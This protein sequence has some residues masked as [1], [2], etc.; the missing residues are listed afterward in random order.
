MTSRKLFASV[1][2]SV[3]PE[4]ISDLVAKPLIPESTTTTA[5][6]RPVHTDY[7]HSTGSDDTDQTE[8]NVVAQA[9][10]IDKVKTITTTQVCTMMINRY[11]IPKPDKPAD[12]GV[13]D[14]NLSHEKLETN[15]SENPVPNEPLPKNE[16]KRDK[17]ISE[18]RLESVLE[19]AIEVD[20]G[21]RASLGL[22][23]DLFNVVPEQDVNVPVVSCEAVDQP[24]TIHLPENEFPLQDIPVSITQGLFTVEQDRI[25][26]TEDM[27]E[28]IAPDAPAQEP[29]IFNKSYTVPVANNVPVVTIKVT[30]DSEHLPLSVLS[31]QV[32]QNNDLVSCEDPI[33]QLAELQAPKAAILVG[34][35]TI[36][37]PAQDRSSE[38][39]FVL[40][41]DISF[42]NQKTPSKSTALPPSKLIFKYPTNTQLLPTQL[43]PHKKD[44]TQSLKTDDILSTQQI[45]A[46][47]F[48]VEDVLI[49]EAVEQ[50]MLL[51]G[52]SDCEWDD[53]GLDSPDT[54]RKNNVVQ[55]LKDEAGSS[56]KLEGLEYQAKV[57]D[58][59]NELSEFPAVLGLLKTGGG[60]AI[61]L[62]QPSKNV[63][64]GMDFLDLKGKGGQSA[65]PKIEKKAEEKSSKRD[66]FEKMFFSKDA[67]LSKLEID[68]AEMLPSASVLNKDPS[69][70]IKGFETASGKYIK[71]ISKSIFTEDFSDLKALNGFPNRGC[72][73]KLVD[74][75]ASTEGVQPFIG[76]KTAA[77]SKISVKAKS[78]FTEDFSDL[79]DMPSFSGFSDSGFSSA[80][81]AVPPPVGF[82]TA[83]GK[84]VTVS[85]TSLDFIKSQVPRLQPDPNTSKQ[86]KSK[87]EMLD[88][89]INTGLSADQDMFGSKDLLNVVPASGPFEGFKT[90]AGSEISI[91]TASI[92][93]EDFSDLKD[94]PLFGFASAGVSTTANETAPPLLGFSTAG[95]KKVT[96]SDETFDFIKFQRPRPSSPDPPVKPK[97][98]NTGF[99]T[100]GGAQVV[101]SEESLD[102]VQSQRS[103]FSTA[104]GKKVEVSDQALEFGKMPSS[105][106]ST[107]GGVRVTISDKALNHIRSSQRPAGFSTASGNDVKISDKSLDFVR[108]QV[109]VAG[110]S[111]GLGTQVKVSDESLDFIK[112]QCPT[113]P[114]GLSN[115]TPKTPKTPCH[116]PLKKKG[117]FVKHNRDNITPQRSK[118]SP[119][120]PSAVATT[121]KLTIPKPE[122]TTPVIIKTDKRKSDESHSKASFESPAIRKDKRR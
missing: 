62:K 116:M 119:T 14:I 69:A 79:K 91:K 88:E 16:T 65:V 84:K 113:E 76:F 107:A 52:V 37:I 81:S 92:F 100:A 68:P 35:Q 89:L 112:S 48:N 99:I 17:L 58:K 115:V 55:L 74:D 10:P 75:Q 29:A 50:A 7:N 108:S 122:L 46:T 120:K 21:W 60:K 36:V 11:K 90:A 51:E 34:T 96:I 15:M 70:T 86:T 82:S 111:T 41:E 56:K 87:I 26:P 42:E 98:F 54:P 43:P 83:G 61:A 24:T 22:T 85:E 67:D 121:P 4:P 38:G 77:G 20:A 103:G 47:Q 102:V 9:K 64:E 53:A 39:S 71:V 13:T 12:N 25:I 28:S 8:D 2:E 80:A 106:F 44:D 31:C 1:P 3:A 94:M 40:E 93:T 63:F 23:Q 27:D 49:A 105:G 30:G 57:A 72:D 118:P 109:P 97:T 6:P 110:F 18:V 45:L 66:M 5:S 95:G 78:I 19:V 73:S 104:A 33:A 114:K 117:G 59:P 101:I 32:P